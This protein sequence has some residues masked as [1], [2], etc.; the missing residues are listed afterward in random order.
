MIMVGP[1]TGVAPFRAFLQERRA[2]GDRGRNW[3]FFGERH[4]AGDFYYRD[5]L[6]ALR[7]DG[8][9][10]RLDLAF[11][12]DQAAKVYVQDRMREHGAQLWAWLQEGAHFYVCGDAGRLAKDAVSY[13]HLDVYKRQGRSSAHAMRPRRRYSRAHSLPG[14]AVRSRR[15]PCCLLYTSRCV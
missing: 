9:L 11:S 6:Q 5:E 13:T 8:L 10:T 4:A 12:R 2:R 3:L 14:S 1:G 15:W 7:D